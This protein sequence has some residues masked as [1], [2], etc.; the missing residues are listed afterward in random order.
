MRI[1]T[2]YN[3]YTDARG[4]DPDRYSATLCEYHRILWSKPL[5]NGKLL[6]LKDT[7]KSA[8]LSHNSDLGRFTFGSDAITHSY[9]NQKPK[10]WITRQIPD[11]VNELFNVGSTIGGYII[12]PNN[13]IDRKMTINQAR[14]VRRLIDDRFDLTLECIR[15][16]YLGLPSPLGDTLV[17]YKTFFD[18][19]ENFMG[20]VRFFLLDDLIDESQS[21]KFY[22]PFDQ[23][24]TQP[25][26]SSTDDYLS[27][28][29]GVMTFIR[30]R[31]G[32][33]RDYCSIAA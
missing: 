22:L 31:N 5:H 25:K 1:N 6:E 33:I 7:P 29:R 14:G 32:R 16:Y 11:E 10:E 12:F 4:R 28:K 27:Y 3:V 26:F 15:L 17:C 23:F 2:D 24:K 13:R 8:Y 19:F 9:K 30:K 21:V 20:Y 18:L